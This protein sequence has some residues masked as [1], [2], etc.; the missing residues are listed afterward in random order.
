MSR[1]TC[2]CKVWNADGDEY[3]AGCSQ[4][5][6]QET[7]VGGDAIIRSAIDRLEGEK[8]TPREELLAEASALITGDR[9]KTYG[10]P[11]QNF[12]DTAEI[13][14]ALLR[15][16]LAPGEA[17]QPG[18]VAMLMVALKLARMKAQPKR[19]N[20]TDVAGYAGCGFEADLESG[21]ITEGGDH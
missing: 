6:Y 5:R 20:W 10:S 8:P 12:Q 7:P 2:E 15:H 16:K 4:S 17:I 19:D 13:W 21:R 9:N 18:E 1:W 11:T 3:C 14:T